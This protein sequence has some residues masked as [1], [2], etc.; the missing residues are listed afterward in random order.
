MKKLFSLILMVLLINSIQAQSS[1]DIAH[2]IHVKSHYRARPQSHSSSDYSFVGIVIF[3]A[4]AFFIGKK[5]HNR[6]KQEDKTM[7]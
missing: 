5:I 2:P 1:R 3:I 6:V 4:L 7:K